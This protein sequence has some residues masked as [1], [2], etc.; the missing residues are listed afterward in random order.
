MRTL[1]AISI[2]LLATLTLSDAWGQV[3]VSVDPHAVGKPIPSNFLGLSFETSATLPGSDGT[4]PYFTSKNTPLIQLFQTLGI[5]SL[6]I[7]G[8]TSDRPSVPVPREADIDQVFAFAHSAGV[9]VVY[10]LR[11][12]DTAP[13]TVQQTAKYIMDRYSQQVDC[14]V[15]GNEPNVYEHTYP[16]YADEMRLFYPAVLEVAPNARFCGPSTTPGAG[17]WVGGYIHDFAS[18]PQLYEVTQHSYPGGNSGKVTGPE[19]GRAAM[20]SAAFPEDYERLYKVFGP[21]ANQAR[22]KYRIEE[23]NSYFNGGAKDVSNT[24]ASSLWALSY[25]YWWLDHDAQGLNFH[26]GDQVAAGEIQTPCW[27]ATF[28]NTPSG[29]DVHPIAY[30]MAAFH[31]ADGGKLTPVTLSKT[32][33]GV[34][35]FATVN[36]AGDIFLTIID[37]NF[38]EAAKPVA[39][40]LSLPSGYGAVTEMALHA[41]GANVAATSGVTLGGGTIESDGRWN[42]RWTKVA[43]DPGLHS[44][45]IDLPAATAMVLKLNAPPK[46]H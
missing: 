10:T 12:R 32:T 24:F 27:Y 43:V 20:L 6:R 14:L 33:P 28:W 11:L 13:L 21:A 34:E 7:G 30:A 36:P 25:L 29:L 35:V 39:F 38:G 17:T 46:R 31:L 4:Y 23:T 3:I 26:T 19:A 18:L 1:K 8:N 42:G 22:V 2:L 40:R 45:T 15:V 41:P 37:K 5:K 9:R 44:V 16:H